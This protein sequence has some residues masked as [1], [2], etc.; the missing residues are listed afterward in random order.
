MRPIEIRG[1]RLT[2]AIVWLVTGLLSLGIYPQQ[3][4]LALLN[5]MGLQGTP[6]LTA[7]Y[8]GATA[9]ITLGVLTMFAPNKKLWVIQALLIITYTLIISIWLTEFW[10]HPFGPILKNLP[11]LI[12]LWLL[13][14]HEGKSQ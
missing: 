11:I 3:D 7:L 14:Q 12:L 6:A 8:I 9:D 2:L 4:S 5:C 1:I 13:Y 10:L